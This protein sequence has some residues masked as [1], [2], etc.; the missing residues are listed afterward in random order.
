MPNLCFYL[1]IWVHF[2]FYYFIYCVISF[3]F[4]ILAGSV[5]TLPAPLGIGARHK[6]LEIGQLKLLK[7]V[8]FGNCA[9]G[10]L[11]RLIPCIGD[12]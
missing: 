1:F 10:L 6:T 3:R 12:I 2:A 9:A 4:L 7:T 8:I 11:F 5:L